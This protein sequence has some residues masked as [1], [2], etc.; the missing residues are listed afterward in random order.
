M[1][2]LHIGNECSWRGGENQI[3]LLI[4]GL[5][6][7]GVENYVAYPA[8]TPGYERLKSLAHRAMALPSKNPLNLKSILHLI[9]FCRKNKIDLIDAHSSG[10]H[11]LAMWVKRFSPQVKLVVHRRVD[12]KIKR[13][14]FSGR[15][16]R[17]QLVDVFIAVSECVRK[18]LIDYGVTEEKIHVIRD[19][20]DPSPYEKIEKKIARQRLL[21]TLRMDSDSD[22]FLIG[23]ASALTHQKGTDTL[24]RA[25]KHLKEE[26]L[27][28]H[29]IIAG[30]GVLRTQLEE[31]AQ[32]LGVDD[33][34]TFLGFIDYVPEFLSGL[35]LLVM[36]SNNEGLGSLLLEGLIASC[37]V[38][39]TSVGGIPEVIKNSE[40]GLL[41]PKGD[42]QALARNIIMAESRRQS[43][44]SGRSYVLENF[45][46]RK[47][48]LETH[49]IYLNLVDSRV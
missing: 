25:V 28:F 42:A 19:G 2:V 8:G 34:V 31:M 43:M 41:S 30:D 16:Y 3:Q 15:K 21:N 5:N 6:A 18:I 26:G 40:I 27:H 17:S 22:I 9:V 1:R 10:G 29:C 38:V 23:N 39:A 36:P 11:S 44:S 45:D 20:V 46:C 37:F 7:A 4:Q 33:R 48:A 24:L 32:E 35:D 13:N 47:M 49:S 14:F 12:N